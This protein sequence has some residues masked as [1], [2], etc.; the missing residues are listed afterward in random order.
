MLS[1][2][3]INIPHW[4]DLFFRV[5]SHAFNTLLCENPKHSLIL[6]D[7]VAQ[8]TELLEAEPLDSLI[9]I[10]VVSGINLVVRS[11]GHF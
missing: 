8:I 2:Q 5:H 1:K 4:K 11:L 6:S 10:N 7:V 9:L 3:F